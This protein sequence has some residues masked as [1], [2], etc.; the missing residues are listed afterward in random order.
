MQ[1]FTHKSFNHG[2]LPYN[3]K[4]AFLGRRVLYLRVSEYLMSRPTSTPSSID[5]LDMDAISTRRLEDILSLQKL[6]DLAMSLDGLPTLLRWKPKDVR[7]KQASGQR[8][9]AAESLMAL[10]GAVESQFG[11]SC[12][13]SFVES[14]IIPGLHVFQ[15]SK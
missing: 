6:G 15:E 12:A 9:V 13:K 8:K 10:V 11:A 2:K 4:L 14:N 3:E 7:D 1:I 5:G